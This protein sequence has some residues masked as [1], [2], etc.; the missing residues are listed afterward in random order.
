MIE[1]KVIDT[2]V[3]ISEEDR[4]IVFEKFRQ[5]KMVIPEGDTLKRGYSGSGLGLSIVR[6]ICRMLEGEIT[7]ESKLGI[8][9]TFTVR[10]PWTLEHKNRAESDMM[11][12]IQQ[13]AMNRVSKMPKTE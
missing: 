1:M 6:E 4:L 12:E 3:G 10:L 7:L 5:G 11:A 13:F 9:S 2:G 8:G